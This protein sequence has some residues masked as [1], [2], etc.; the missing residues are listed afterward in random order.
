[1]TAPTDVTFVS[2][3]TITS[4]WLNGVND[5][6]NELETFVHTS[7]KIEFTP[8]GAGAVN[9]G[10]QSKLRESVSVM[11]FGAVG[12]GV[13]DDTVNIQAAIDSG[14]SKIFGVP[15]EIY[16]I[17]SQLLININ[18]VEID[19]Q[20]AQLLLDDAT[21][22]KNHIKL[23]DGVTQRT[24]IRLKNIAFA[25]QQ[26]ATAGYA[27]DSD[28]IG[29]VDITGCRIYGNN[30]I[31]NGIKIRRG[32][33][34]NIKDNYI[35]N[36]LNLGIYLEGT[37]ATTNRTIDVS[38]LENRIEGGISALSTWD[39]VE[40]VFCHD[41]IFFNTSSAAVTCSASSNVNGLSSFKF[42]DN[43]FDTAAAGLFVNNI[44]NIQVNNNWFSAITG[45]GADFG[46]N[47]V[48]TV[49]A[50]NQMYPTSHGIRYAGL[51]AR[52]NANIISGG[53]ACVYL[54]STASRC[55]V[56]G[57]T[58][59]SAAYGVNMAEGATN[60]HIAGNHI[61]SMSSGIISGETVGA[62]NT[63]QSNKGDSI[64]GASSFI[65]VG[66][67]PFTYTAG[68]RTEY[69]SVFSGTVSNLQLGASSFGFGT[70]RSIVLAPG[71]SV[72]VTYSS[73]PTML[74]NVL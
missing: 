44:S 49:I 59:Q 42:K 27:I 71:Q 65:T 57:N 69:V 8:A 7:D 61:Y 10:V 41:N 55:S 60:C 28:F 14:V 63:V 43:D 9:R 73:A 35:D 31:Y 34:V 13:T 2:G 16:K 68:V 62:G 12:D 36:C 52:I 37:D 56:V 22:L 30:K 21:G 74:K 29:V 72:T 33:I 40:G 64:V 53:D 51:D 25:R 23:G 20:H 4:N 24:G 39:F 70:N 5:H 54:R 26:V 32:I 38:I 67:S 19:F 6:V 47:V 1:M 18:N 15:G 3:T 17:S 11:D 48:A 50:G 46:A 45:I 58:L 66:A